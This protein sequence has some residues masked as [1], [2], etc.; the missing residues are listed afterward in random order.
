M[1]QAQR[2]PCMTPAAISMLLVHL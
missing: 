2:I 1:G